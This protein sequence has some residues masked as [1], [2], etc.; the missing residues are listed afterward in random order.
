MQDNNQPNSAAPEAEQPA[1]KRQRRT[2]GNEWLR[3]WAWKREHRPDKVRFDRPYSHGMRL[4]DGEEAKLTVHQA[5]FREQGFA[6]TVW[7]SS[8]VLAKLFERQ[9]AAVQGK[10]CLDLSAGCG[11]PCL[12]LA[13][14]GAGAVVAT[15]LAPNLPLLRKNAEANGCAIQVLEHS[16][17]EDVAPLGPPF[18][19]IAACDVMYVAEAVEPLVA[20][21][22]ALSGPHSRIYI[23][24]GRN[25]Q[26]EPQFLAAAG[27]HFTIQTVPSEDLDEVYQCADVDVLLLTLKEQKDEKQ[28]KS[29]QLSEDATSPRAAAAVHVLAADIREASTSGRTSRSVQSAVFMAAGAGGAA[30]NPSLA[31]RNRKTELDLE[32][33]SPAVRRLVQAF[34]ALLPPLASAPGGAGLLQEAWTALLGRVLTGASIGSQL[35]SRVLHQPACADERLAP[36]R[37]ALADC[38]AQADAVLAGLRADDAAVVALEA[39][40]RVAVRLT[41]PFYSTSGALHVLPWL[42]HAVWVHAPSLRPSGLA[43]QPAYQS[44]AGSAV[45]AALNHLAAVHQVLEDATRSLPEAARESVAVGVLA[46]AGAAIMQAHLHAGTAEELLT[47]RC[48]QPLSA[49]DAGKV[50]KLVSAL[51][52]ALAPLTRD[53]RKLGAA[54]EFLERGAR[55]LRLPA[56]G[57]ARAMWAVLSSLRL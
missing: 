44:A 56:D 53:A 21:L 45:A 40:Q 32:E 4:P 10:R 29:K 24:H 41:L 2:S 34:E 49:A 20:S 35:S 39:M 13:K 9:A 31:T 18:D 23:S 17:G 19:I 11:L 28:E 7:D 55:I 22:C 3:S 46:A 8:I 43:G 50:S 6:S 5:R 33:P 38:A 52:Q 47:L 12:V 54:A 37:R 14:L 1:A 25:R 27:Q 36:A 26:A 51:L 48:L 16:W 30:V 15:D 42:E 57:W